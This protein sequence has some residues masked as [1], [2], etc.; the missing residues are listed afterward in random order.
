MT[1]QEIGLAMIALSMLLGAVIVLVE[2][3]QKK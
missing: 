3:A 2:F 1:T